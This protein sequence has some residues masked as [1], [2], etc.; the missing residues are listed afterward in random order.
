MR[1]AVLG[2]CQAAGVAAS[3]CRLVPGAEVE[4]HELVTI[5]NG[6]PDKDP[7]KIARRISRHEIVFTQK[8]EQANAGPLRTS[9]LVKLA[10]RV[11]LYP[12]ISFEGFH[13]DA[14]YIVSDGRHL[15][16]P[17]GSYHSAIVAGAFLAGIP[18]KRTIGLFNAYVYGL[19]DFNARYDNA[20]AFLDVLGDRTGIDLGGCVADWQEAGAWM[21]TINHPHLR[22]LFAVARMS[23]AKAGIP[24][25]E[26]ATADG[27]ADRLALDTIW[28]LYPELARRLQ[29]Q[30]GGLTFI[31]GLGCCRPGEPR[32]LDLEDFVG[33]SYRI[34]SELP[35]ATLAAIPAVAEAASRLRD[36]LSKPRALVAAMVD[37][38][39][40]A[41][42]E[43]FVRALY[44]TVLGRNP[45]PAGL[46][47]WIRQ[48]RTKGLPE[49][50][51]GS[52]RSFCGSVEGRQKLRTLY[53]DPN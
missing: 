5:G 44:R 22:V 40:D 7:E 43:G 46:E 49:A 50:F 28:P 51:E 48:V 33:Q 37:D 3:L 17:V 34:Y 36:A 19:L 16:S 31:K 24:Y 30:G 35:Q 1:I 42:A 53:P 15:H 25:E 52:I 39:E 10:Q 4:A 14:T 47:A 9:S 41:M 12:S 6:R 27:M 11:E 21:H 29:L 23:L 13:P 45:D 2:N 32:E 8:Y 20:K 38:P 26:T 18:A